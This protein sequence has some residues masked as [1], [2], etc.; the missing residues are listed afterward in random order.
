MDV[1]ACTIK[2]KFSRVTVGLVEKELVLDNKIYCE[3]D[4]CWPRWKAAG[5]SLKQLIGIPEDQDIIMVV[6]WLS[7]PREKY[8]LFKFIYSA[9]L[10]E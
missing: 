8:Q 2:K 7:D 6:S 4:K 10:K 5:K 3:K 9:G 1:I